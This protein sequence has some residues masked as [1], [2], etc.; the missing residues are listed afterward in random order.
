M[1]HFFEKIFSNSSTLLLLAH[2]PQASS[3]NMQFS[4]SQSRRSN[5]LIYSFQVL[6]CFFNYIFSLHF[7]IFQPNFNFILFQSP[8]T[9]ILFFHCLLYFFYL[10]DSIFF[11]KSRVTIAPLFPLLIHLSFFFPFF[12]SSLKISPF[13]ITS[14]FVFHFSLLTNHFFTHNFPFFFFKPVFFSFQ[15]V[16]DLTLILFCICL[17]SYKSQLLYFFFL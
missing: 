8:F 6:F 17:I 1:I 9:T 11:M 3:E 16:L 10:F 15:F 13:F 14:I 4:Q 2:R 5:M 7:S 12:I